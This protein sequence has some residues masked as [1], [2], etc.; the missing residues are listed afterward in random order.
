MLQTASQRIL[1]QAIWTPHGDHPS[2]FSALTPH[3]EVKGV[4]QRTLKAKG[5]QKWG[6]NIIHQIG[7]GVPPVDEPLS[8]PT[9]L[10]APPCGQRE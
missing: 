5:G 4:G 1:L 7:W 2:F 8:P 3:P 10:L 6:N 9:F